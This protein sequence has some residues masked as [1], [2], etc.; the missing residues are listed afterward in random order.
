MNNKNKTEI[1]I[2]ADAI[3]Y[4][5]N[6]LKKYDGLLSEYGD[7]TVSKRT[8]SER[9]I[10][11]WEYERSKLEYVLGLSDKRPIFPFSKEEVSH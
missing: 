8:V 3:K 2:A 10:A 6:E 5:R 11:M 1:E 9:T 7:L 4:C